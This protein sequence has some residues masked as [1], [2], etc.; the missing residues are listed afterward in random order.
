MKHKIYL[1]IGLLVLTLSFGSFERVF[2]CSCEKETP[3]N[4]FQTADVVFVGKVIEIKK[5]AELAFG[6]YLEVSEAFKGVKVGEIIKIMSVQNNGGGCGYKFE[7][8][9]GYLVFSKNVTNRDGIKGFWTYQCSG[10]RSLE[11][12]EDSI[13][14]LR[15]FISESAE[16]MITGSVEDISR[17]YFTQ[18]VPLENIKIKAERLGRNK[19]VF[20]GTADKSGYFIIKV[21]VGTYMVTPELPEN[22]IF[23]VRD[24][25]ENK[26]IRV[27]KQKCNGKSFVIVKQEK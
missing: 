22:Y 5:E 15:S 19:Q 8:D 20:Y 16:T 1:F 13:N 6:V 23:G 24:E 21:P 27:E 7:K 11:Y 18:F 4:T 26:P 17:R 9:E 12:A 14:F 10:T 3:C 25:K 2:A